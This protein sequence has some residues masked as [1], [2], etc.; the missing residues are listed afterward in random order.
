MRFT[1]LEEGL[2]LIQRSPV[3]YMLLT[4]SEYFMHLAKEMWKQH[5]AESGKY[6][7]LQSKPLSV[8]FFSPAK[9][10]LLFTHDH[11]SP[12]NRVLDNR[13]RNWEPGAE[14]SS[15]AAAGKQPAGLEGDR[16]KEEENFWKSAG[17]SCSASPLRKYQMGLCRPV[18]WPS[19]YLWAFWFLAKGLTEHVLGDRMQS[20]ELAPTAVGA[21]CLPEQYLLG[22]LLVSYRQHDQRGQAVVTCEEWT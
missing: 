9:F 6:M 3:Q 10:C 1:S 4:T 21:A 17:K 13:I 19:S 8:T 5:D 12:N 15:S 14:L 20:G 2:G 16:E 22:Y 7:A 11:Y 18:E